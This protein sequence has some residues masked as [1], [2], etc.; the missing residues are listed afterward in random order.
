MGNREWNDKSH[1]CWASLFTKHLCTQHLTRQQSRREAGVSVMVIDCKQQKPILNSLSRE[2]VYQKVIKQLTETKEKL[3]NEGQRTGRNQGGLTQ[4]RVF[5]GVCFS[6]LANTVTFGND[7]D[8]FSRG[9]WLPQLEEHA[10]LDLSVVSLSPVL[11]AETIKQNKTNQTHKIN[12]G[13]PGWLCR[14]SVRPWLRS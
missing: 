9:A 12:L 8:R 2:G 11:C 14:L 10:T 7:Q 3:E 4:T 1:F 6:S 13:A 5:Q